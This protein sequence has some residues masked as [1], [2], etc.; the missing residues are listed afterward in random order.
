[1]R[2]EEPMRG[3]TIAS[4]AF[5]VVV[6]GCGGSAATTSASAPASPTSVATSSAASSGASSAATLTGLLGAYPSLPSNQVSAATAADLQKV[7][8]DVLALHSGIAAASPGGITAAVIAP[9]CGTWSG[10]TGHRDGSAP[11][12]ADT[13]FLLA[14]V[15]KSVTAAAVLRLATERRISLDAPI[16]TYLPGDLHIDTNGATVRQ[17]LQMRSGLAEVDEG[18]AL[19]SR[20][21][22]QPDVPIDRASVLATMGPATAKPGTTT[23]YVD[24]NY[25]LLGYVIEKAGGM[26]V[27]QAFRSLVLKDPGLARL[28]Y[29]DEERPQGPLALGYVDPT[30]W[31][32]AG[33]Q[34]GLEKAL[35][36][37][38]VPSR[39]LASS[40]STAVAAVSDAPTLARWGYLLYGGEIVS[41]ASLALMTTFS[42]GDVPYGMGT[43]D[44][45]WPFGEHGIGHDGWWLGY[46]T[47]LLTRPGS[48]VTVAVLSNDERLQDFW[49]IADQLADIAEKC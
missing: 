34:A 27:A 30:L 13:Q 12:T 17:L 11:M 33:T 21:L 35:A 25:I 26:S 6:A 39:S 38:Y 2:E 18:E 46:R 32:Q 22:A 7:L 43:H 1:M 29:E 47:A 42:T 3:R 24:T 48:A 36:G 41:R 14:S 40:V 49:K 31:T 9:K 37:G 20:G 19:V 4:L 28:V 8:D 23:E 16:A 45:S 44:L 10:A 5:A 15:T